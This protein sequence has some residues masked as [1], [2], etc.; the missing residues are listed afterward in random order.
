MSLIN[1]FNLGLKKTS[2]FITSNILNSISSNKINIDI[3]DDIENTLIS[4]DLGIEVTNHLINKL[5]SIKLEKK[6]ET[7]NIIELLSTEI[8]EILSKCEKK[9]VESNDLLPIT[10]LFIGVNGSGKTT[11]IGKLIGKIKSE[12]K[13]LVAACDTF[14]AAAVEQLKEWT[15]RHEVDIFIGNINQDPAS[16]A[17]DA[18]E[19]VKKES[20]DYLMVDTAGRLSNN[21]NLLNQLIKI[22]S[23]INKSLSEKI[24]KTVLVLDGTNGSNMINQVKIFAEALDVNGLIITKLDGTAKGGALISIAKKYQLPIYFVGLG[25]KDDDLFAFN[26]KEFSKS[27]LETDT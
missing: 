16:V 2:S 22:K 12:K 8:S 21:T 7:K 13:I 23:V 14:R 10:F 5:K 1:K 15:K 11:T 6:I 27:L 24:I 9:I 4:A 20:Y 17:Y 26:A 19:K 3:I 25:E 18:C